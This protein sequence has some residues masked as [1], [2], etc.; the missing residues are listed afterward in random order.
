MKLFVP[1]APGRAHA[2]SV[3]AA[4][5]WKCLTSAPSERN[6]VQKTPMKCPTVRDSDAKSYHHMARAYSKLAAGA[7]G[8]DALNHSATPSSR[9]SH[10]LAIKLVN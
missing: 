2:V 7:D 3:S 5:I 4:R 8:T 10:I 1:D 9:Q 6:A